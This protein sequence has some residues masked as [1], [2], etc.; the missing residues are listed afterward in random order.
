MSNSQ[1]AFK[2]FD[3]NIRLFAKAATHPEKYNLYNGLANIAK[4]IQ[5]L[6]SEV[7]RLRTEIVRLRTT[8]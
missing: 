2:C 3:E 7:A 5:E 4:A 8:P 1:N 6:E